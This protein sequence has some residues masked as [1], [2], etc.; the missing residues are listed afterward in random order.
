MCNC[1]VTVLLCAAKV[2]KLCLPECRQPIARGKAQSQSTTCGPAQPGAARF[3]LSRRGQM[4]LDSGGVNDQQM[5]RAFATGLPETRSF[6]V[7]VWERLQRQVMKEHRAH[8]LL[9]G[10]P[11]GAEPLRKAIATYLNLERGPSAS[12]NR[13]WC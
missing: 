8:I 3:G 4:I 11:Q 7:A 10:D 9:H 1:S 5:I 13:F 2:R 12:P 6:P